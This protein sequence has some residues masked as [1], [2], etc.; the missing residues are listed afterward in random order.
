MLFKN[1]FQ[2]GEIRKVS[3]SPEKVIIYPYGKP[4]VI[5]VPSGDLSAS[6]KSDEDLKAE[7]SPVN[8]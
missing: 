4:A 1:F 8:A 3:I 2:S 5:Y 6:F 7:L